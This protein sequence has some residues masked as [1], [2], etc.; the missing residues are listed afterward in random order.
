MQYP[1]SFSPV[2]RHADAFSSL[3]SGDQRETF[4]LLSR[5]SSRHTY[6]GPRARKAVVFVQK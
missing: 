2:A 5:S 4:S 1:F 3:T 6:F